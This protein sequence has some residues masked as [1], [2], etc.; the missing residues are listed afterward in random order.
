MLSDIY[1]DGDGKDVISTYKKYHEILSNE[2]DEIDFEMINGINAINYLIP[3]DQF[4]FKNSYRNYKGLSSVFKNCPNN[5]EYQIG[6]YRTSN[7]G[8]IYLTYF[9]AKPM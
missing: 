9:S 3:N 6:I 2:C 8:R 5:T 1:D 4:Y 7:G